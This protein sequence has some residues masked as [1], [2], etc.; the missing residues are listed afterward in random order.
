MRVYTN[1][2]IIQS[3]AKWAKRIAPLTMLFL[4]GG[5]I[6][7]FMSMSQPQYFQP[8]LI[9][10]AL[11]FVFATTSSHLVNR[12]V[13]EPRADQVLTTTLKKFGND[14]V[15]FNYT[16]PPPHVLL[17]PNRLYAI[18]VKNQDGQTIVNGRRYSR[19]F[20]WNRFFRFFADEGLG[21]PAAEAENRLDKLE[22]FLRKNL[23]DEEMPEL[24]PLILFTHKDAELI[25]NDSDIPVMRT[26]ELKTYLR[27]QEKN[28]VI[29][30]A[31]R[32]KLTQILGGQG[33]EAK[34]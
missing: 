13:R 30:P 31:Q 23:T 11:G 19:K 25:V 9:L 5:L 12:W 29:S 15:L 2:N 7:N 17:T 10:L 32:Q 8:T 27:E 24:K 3:R 4:I 21:S 16:V 33:E 20:T 6:T 18:V 26:N 34:E 1:N 28:R 22:K 14:F